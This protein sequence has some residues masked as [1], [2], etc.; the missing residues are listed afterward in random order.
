MDHLSLACKAFPFVISIKKSAQARTPEA[1]IRLDDKLLEPVKKFCYPGSTITSTT[2]LDEEIRVGR[3]E[4][5]RAF[6]RLTKRPWNNKLHTIKTKIRM[7]EA[8][9]LST[10]LYCSETRKK[11]TCFLASMSAEDSLHQMSRK[12]PAV[13]DQAKRSD[14]TAGPFCAKRD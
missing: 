10:L 5:A 9:A 6:G 2:S 12:S 3:G 11:T 1:T 8:C 13:L 7:Y 4:A 14:M